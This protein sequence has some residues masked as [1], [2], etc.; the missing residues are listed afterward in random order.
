MKKMICAVLAVLLLALS[1]AGCSGS[2]TQFESGAPTEEQVSTNSSLPLESGV[3]TE[4]NVSS[5]SGQS[6]ESGPLQAENASPYS[7]LYL[8][9]GDR[10][11]VSGLCAMRFTN[12]GDKTISEA[13]LT[14]T[15]GQ[16][17]LQFR[18]E[19]LSAGQSVL[20]AE[21]NQHPATDAELQYVDGQIHYLEDGLVE[22]KDC[23][24]LQLQ[25]DGTL[26]IRNVTGEDLP[27]VRVFFRPVNE[28]GEL[29]GGPCESVLADGIMAGEAALVEGS[30]WDETCAVVT[31]LLI[32]E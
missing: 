3:P 20:V 10:E 29:L 8:E 32:N 1:C 7:G 27:L 17:E 4:E 22:Q 30:G 26:Q 9:Y 14:F 25:Q 5:D 2:Q 12:T 11:L 15:D 24:E 13:R 21:Y 28:S 31:V 18:L 23:V 16:K 6:P 19:M